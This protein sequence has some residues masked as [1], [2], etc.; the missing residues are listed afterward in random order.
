MTPE[1]GGVTMKRIHEVE[2]RGWSFRQLLL[3]GLAGMAAGATLVCM[4]APAA[5]KPRRLRDLL[6]R[7]RDEVEAVP[8][9]LRRAGHAAREAFARSIEDQVGDI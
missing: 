1:P 8:Q 2:C 9:A 7:G 3:A 4:A 6:Q 5:S